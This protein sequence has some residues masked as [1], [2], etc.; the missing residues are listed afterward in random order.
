MVVPLRNSP[1]LLGRLIRLL[2]HLGLKNP[3]IISDFR[4]RTRMVQQFRSSSRSS[5]SS[6][7][8]RR[9]R[10]RRVW[11]AQ[12]PPSGA[13]ALLCCAPPYSAA[14]LVRATIPA[15][16]SGSPCTTGPHTCPDVNNNSVVN[17]DWSWRQGVEAVYFLGTHNLIFVRVLLFSDTLRFLSETGARRRNKRGIRGLADGETLLMNLMV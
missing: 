10:R 3:S 7:R 5:S 11:C 2:R 4:H 14:L 16:N 17:N 1:I 15:P 8:R 6:R 12:L 13:A 9:R